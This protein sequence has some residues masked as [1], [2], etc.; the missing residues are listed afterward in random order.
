MHLALSL[1]SL[2]LLFQ[3]IELRLPVRVRLAVEAAGLFRGEVVGG[4]YQ[5]Q[6][7]GYRADCEDEDI[8]GG[9]VHHLQL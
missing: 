2:I 6:E 8:A 9:W 3:L 1:P 4:G 7:T 5:H